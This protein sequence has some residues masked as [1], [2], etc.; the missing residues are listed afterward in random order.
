MSESKDIVASQFTALS[1]SDSKFPM[2]EV[3][4]TNFPKGVTPSD[5]DR[6]KVPAGGATSWEITTLKGTESVKAIEGIILVADDNRVF[7]KDA[8]DGENTPPDCFSPDGEIGFGEPGGECK[9]CPL[10]QWGSAENGV[11]QACSLRKNMLILKPD[12]LLPVIISAPPG[13]IGTV[14]DYLKRITSAGLPHFAVVTALKLGKKKSD[15]GITYAV[16]E[17]DFVRELTDDE[18]EKM[19]E[20]RTQVVP[21]FAEAAR[22]PEMMSVT[23]DPVGDGVAPPY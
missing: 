1:K 16:I 11:G 17:P 4:A 14:T 21:A 22:E 10:A 6:I 13:S 7:Y 5:L 9:V 8:Y 23:A 20:Y 19:R 12:A 18:I 2:K 15:S 3:L